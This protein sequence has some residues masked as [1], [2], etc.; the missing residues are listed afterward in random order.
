M[1]ELRCGNAGLNSSWNSTEPM[2]PTYFRSAAEMRRWFMRHHQSATELL[3]G[4][5]KVASGEPSIGWPESVDEAL[6][7][8]WIDGVRK[9]LDDSRYTI[10]FTPRKPVSTW[11]AVNIVRAQALLDAGR[12]LASG[13]AAYEARR[14]NRVGV[15]SYE[16]RSVELPPVYAKLLRAELAAWQYLHACPASYKKA[17]VWWVVS[18]K[19]EA[20][21]QRRLAQLIEHCQR[22]QRIAAF[23]RP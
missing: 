18:A 5:H 11:S 4:L 14:E 6:C 7:V 2:E 15:Y 8:G 20:T 22:R 3:V 12:M 16:Q 13:L 1:L 17:V 10:R 9:R 19:Q 23:S 21:R